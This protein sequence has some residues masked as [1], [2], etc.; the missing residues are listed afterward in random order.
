MTKMTQLEVARAGRISPEMSAVATAEGI[1]PETLRQDIAAGRTVIPANPAHRS[2]RPVGIGRG[3][4]IKVNAN[5][6]LSGAVTASAEGE[7]SKLDVALAAGADA[8][9]DLSTGSSEAMASARRAVIARSSVPVGTV[10]IYQAAV[11]AQERGGAVVGM[12]AEEMFRAVEEHAADGVDFVT[13]HCG[14][15]QAALEAL[16]ASRRL[17]GVVS[18]GGAFTVAWMLHH[19]EDN[20][21]YS[22]FDRLLDIARRHDV[23]LSLGDG[24]RPGCIADATD[25]AQVAELVTL[26]QLVER[27]RDAGVQVMVEGPGHIP[28]HQVQANVTLAKALCHGAPFYVLG[29][30]VTDSAAGHDHVAA[31]IGGALAGWAGA[32]FLCYVTP[33]E[34]L[35]LPDAAHVHEGVVA[36]RIAAHAADL[37]RRLP[38]AWQRDR[39]MSLARREMDWQGQ[40]AQAIDGRRACE[41]R[42]RLNPATAGGSGGDERKP[43]SM[44]GDLCA[45]EIA[46]RAMG[47]GCL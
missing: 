33:A 22:G 16:R 43:C 4:R 9:M 31:A 19:G 25:A 3:L 10:P 20:P 5:I 46:K 41:L 34:H 47:G 29:P 24:M 17:T 8:V 21:F 44:C 7:A 28:L 42:Q 30:L 12:T 6:G 36:A 45:I 13:V 40:I 14:V 27:A 18:R 15:N 39:A 32:D 2:L 38:S 26:G 37:A 23:T 35:G 11:Q 1:D